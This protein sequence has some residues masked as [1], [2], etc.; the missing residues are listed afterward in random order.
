M[1]TLMADQGFEGEGGTS[2]GV[3]RGGCR[4]Q[5]EECPPVRKGRGHDWWEWLGRVWEEYHMLPN[6]V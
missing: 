3:I 2:E 1:C 6:M 4:T 5:R